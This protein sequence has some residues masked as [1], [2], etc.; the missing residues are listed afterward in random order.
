MAGGEADLSANQGDWVVLTFFATWCGP[1]RSEMPTLEE[2]HRS[3]GDDG[4]AVL[5][6]SV[7]RRRDPVEPF[8]DEH[9][10]TLPVFWDQRGE[11]GNAYRATSIP[12]SYVID[13]GGRIVGMARGA[14][15]W[16]ATAPLFD[17]LQKTQ[18][19]T[20]DASSHYAR[21]DTLELPEILE[22]PTAEWS[23]PA[24]APRPGRP[25]TIE[26][27]L[28]WSGRIEDYLPQ[29]PQIPLPEGIS[30]GRRGGQQQQPRP[31]PSGALSD[32][33]DRRRG[34]RLR[35]RPDRAALSAG[36]GR[37]PGGGPRRRPDRS[38]WWP[39]ASP[40]DRRPPWRTW[41]PAWPGGR[42]AL[43]AAPSARPA[44]CDTGARPMAAPARRSR[45][46]QGAAPG[47]RGRR[48]LRGPGGAPPAS[49][50]RPTSARI[51]SDGWSPCASAATFRTAPSSKRSSAGSS[52]LWPDGNPTPTRRG[53]E[54]LRLRPR[55]SDSS[56]LTS[57]EI[58]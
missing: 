53:A 47:R 33:A 38:R 54:R 41:P 37:R 35:A 42:L 18:P 20:P 39:P 51:S 27:R 40:G 24:E 46:R 26:V 43:P 30:R 17:A 50:R 21:L 52:E 28:S 14:R 6:V 15:D 16:A 9:R 13:P 56:P 55:P 32:R 5:A 49:W 11:V 48:R 4:L 58:S 8:V 34:R 7:D 12:V 36:A 23:L 44:T 25:F 1:C 19:A 29:P 31:Q 10:L 45:P 22:P 3:R 57:K 2:L